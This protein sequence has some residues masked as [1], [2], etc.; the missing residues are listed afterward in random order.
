MTENKEPKI[1]GLLLAAGG[2]SRL[3]RP[4]QLV[5]FEGKTLIR[6]AVEALTEA[7]CNPV[8]VVLGGEI[9]GSRK[10]LESL[11][12]EIL[13]NQDWRDGMSSSVRIGISL[14]R[15]WDVDAVLISLC[16]QPH[17]GSDDLRKLIDAFSETA[18]S[19]VAAQYD[20]ILGVPALFSQELF[21]DL[22]SLTGDSGARDLIRSRG[23]FA[24]PLPE[25][26]FD[27]DT[28]EDL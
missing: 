13:E 11:S 27:V 7:G 5:E 15:G 10:A 24:V 12:V 20:G 21:D 23:S 14:L 2:S 18:S 22:A 17:I 28:R 1:A 16:D 19:I 6:R 26:S 4:K 3:G 8:V 9:D 25:A